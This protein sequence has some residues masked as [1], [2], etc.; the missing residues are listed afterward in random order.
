[1]DSRLV[2]P[3]PPQTAVTH[4]VELIDQESKCGLMDL[5]DSMFEWDDAVLIKG[6]I[7]LCGTWLIMVNSL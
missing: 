4:V 2:S 5:I 3:R 6:M 1:M 7:F